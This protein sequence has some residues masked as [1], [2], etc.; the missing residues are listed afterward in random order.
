MEKNPQMSIFEAVTRHRISQLARKY[1]DELVVK[2]WKEIKTG[3]DEAFFS[4][5]GW[6]PE[7]TQMEA[8]EGLNDY[9]DFVEAMI[10]KHQ[11]KEKENRGS[12]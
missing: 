5:C 6:K 9:C 10:R 2:I 12:Y 3:G 4:G 8:L 1:G 11:G 7:M